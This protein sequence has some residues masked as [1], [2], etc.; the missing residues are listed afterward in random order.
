MTGT[1]YR[2]SF[3]HTFRIPI[4]SYFGALLTFSKTLKSIV[5]NCDYYQI[6][7]VTFNIFSA[8]KQLSSTEEHIPVRLI[9][10]PV[11]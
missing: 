4:D 7:R 9:F 1:I 10:T 2:H 8:S 6:L 3:Q 11:Q 5:R